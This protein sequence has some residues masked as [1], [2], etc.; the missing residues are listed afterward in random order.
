MEFVEN[1]LGSFG[2][3]LG[4]FIF[5]LLLLLQVYSGLDIWKGIVDDFRL[6]DFGRMGWPIFLYNDLKMKLNPLEGC[7]IPEKNLRDRHQDR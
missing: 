5:L 3:G 2:F 4:F 7:S 6:D 1:S